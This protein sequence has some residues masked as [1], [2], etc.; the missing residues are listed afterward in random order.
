[1]NM[2]EPGPSA[3]DALKWNFLGN[4]NLKGGQIKY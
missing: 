3:T 2:E 4:K 1:M